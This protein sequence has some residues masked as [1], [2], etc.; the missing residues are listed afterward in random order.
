MS[1]ITP[2]Y[3]HTLEETA[4][5]IADYPYSFKLR[6]QRKCWLEFKDKNGY[7]LMVMTSNP[8]KFGIVWNKPHASTYVKIAAC[9]YLDEDGYVQWSALTEYSS[10]TDTLAFMKN[11]PDYPEMG[12]LSLWCR[13]KSRLVSK[14]ADGLAIFTLNQVPQMPSASEVEA[15]REEKK[16]W[17]ECISLYQGKQK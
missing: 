13:G 12:I 8:R 14:T 3:G 1:V 2:L 11:F 4:Y 9:M 16:V 7:R 10:A 6:C 17:D 5:L 15:A